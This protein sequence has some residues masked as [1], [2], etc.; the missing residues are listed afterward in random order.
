MTPTDEQES[1]RMIEEYNEDLIKSLDTAMWIDKGGKKTKMLEMDTEFLL[2]AF[3]SICTREVDA[4]NKV[5][6]LY[7]VR[8]QLEEVA[9]IKGIVLE[10]PD[11]KF[12]HARWGKY[13]ESVRKTEVKPTSIASENAIK[14]TEEL[15]QKNPSVNLS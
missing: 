3:T 7:R 1:N 6:T 4:Y 14:Q 10:W 2:K 11:I 5:T 12:P 9:K 15:E 13:L 8:E